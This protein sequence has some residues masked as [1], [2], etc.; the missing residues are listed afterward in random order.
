VIVFSEMDIRGG[1]S[2]ESHSHPI[3]VIAIIAVLAP[4]I[5]ELPLPF[6]IPAVVLEIMC[7]ILVGPQVFGWVKPD[8]AVDVL[9]EIGLCL[10]FLLA[11]IEIDFSR[12]FVVGL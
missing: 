4:L 10:L 12:A 8:H 7:G 5:S 9:R 2:M 11:G 3:L 6:R 1:R